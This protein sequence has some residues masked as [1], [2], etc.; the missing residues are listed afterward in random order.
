M[1]DLCVV[2][3]FI[4]VLRTVRRES[5]RRVTPLVPPGMSAVAAVNIALEVLDGCALA[6]DH[7][8]D[9]VAN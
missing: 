1:D 3:F 4:S 2:P 9:Q 8:L 6:I 5:P 7:M